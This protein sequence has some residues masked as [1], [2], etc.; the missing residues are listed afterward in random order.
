M[1]AAIC[2]DSTL[3]Y[4][5]ERK[6]KTGSGCGS[7]WYILGFLYSLAMTRQGWRHPAAIKC[8]GK[9]AW[10]L[11]K[12]T[13]LFFVQVF[14]LKIYPES[15]RHLGSSAAFSFLF[16]YFYLFFLQ[17]ICKLEAL[18]VV[19]INAWHCKLMAWI[20]VRHSA[21]PT[22]ATHVPVEVGALC[23]LTVRYTK[24]D[25]TWELTVPQLNQEH[26]QSHSSRRQD[27]RPISKRYCWIFFLSIIKYASHKS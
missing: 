10:K 16:I 22:T 8:S 4:T 14:F 23:L 19:P 21:S 25:A 2:C 11:P 1:T 12:G 3:N 20:P 7:S 26:I 13:N 18:P 5:D 9:E 6:L 17:N 24:D 27:N 15:E